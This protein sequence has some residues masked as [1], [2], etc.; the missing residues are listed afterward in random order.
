MRVVIQAVASYDTLT[1]VDSLSLKLVNSSTPFALDADR[2]VEVE[3][4][5]LPE[6]A[7][8]LTGNTK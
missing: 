5:P 8:G 4:L 3:T 1:Y 6:A 2:S 7:S